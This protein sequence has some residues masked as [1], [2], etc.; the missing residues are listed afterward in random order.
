MA[1]EYTDT[2]LSDLAAMVPANLHR[3]NLSAATAIELLNVSENATYALRDPTGRDWVLRVHRV[4]YSSP[5]EIRSELAWLNAL[6]RDRVIETAA[7]IPGADGEWVQRLESRSGAPRTP[8][9]FRPHHGVDIPTLAAKLGRQRP[10]SR[11]SVHARREFA[12]P[13]E[14]G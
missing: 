8:E 14:P 13:L 10:S 5:E 4:G 3:W 9:A 1:V 2:I 12:E 6:R 11:V 7:P